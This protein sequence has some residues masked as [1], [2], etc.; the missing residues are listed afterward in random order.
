MTGNT[1]LGRQGFDI[2]TDAKTCIR[3]QGLLDDGSRVIVINSPE[4]R[5]R[6]SIQ[7]P[8]LVKNMSACMAMCPP[9]PHAFLVVIPV[10]SHQ[11]REWTV[12]GP[13]ELL[14]DTLLRN[15]IVVIGFVNKKPCV[16]EL[17]SPIISI[18]LTLH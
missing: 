8:G 13:L 17:F 18:I 7:D 2:S 4:R 11:G 16:Q 12:E 1:I 14:N 5:V 10:G 15:T 9:G 6:Y 3:R